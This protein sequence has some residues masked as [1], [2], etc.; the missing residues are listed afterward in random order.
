M[1]ISIIL[2]V[3][4]PTAGWADTVMEKS[5]ELILLYPDDDFELIVVDDGS[6]PNSFREAYQK[7]NK[8]NIH[9][10]SHTPNKGKGYALKQGVMA[11]TGD[12]TVYTDVDFPYTIGSM[13]SMIDLLK[14]K[15]ADVCIGIRELSYYEHVPAVRRHISLLFRKFIKMLFRTVTDDT[16]CGLKGFNQKGKVIFLQTEIDRYLFDLEFVYLSSRAAGLVVKTQ[17]VKLRADVQFRKMDF[18][19]LRNEFWN[20]LKLLSRSYFH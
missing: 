10:L 1:K 2:P 4:N 6:D 8:H 17:E 5:A 9:I 11:A 7:F 19:I 15:D 20:F 18:G 14:I 12:L 13:C 16:Q 3:Y